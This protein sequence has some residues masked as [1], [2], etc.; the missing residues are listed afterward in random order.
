[1]PQF[2]NH[3]TRQI[4]SGNERESVRVHNHRTMLEKWRMAHF[5]TE[6]VE[7]SGLMPLVR[8]SYKKVL[9]LEWLRNTFSSVT[10]N[11]DEN[12]RTCATRAFLLYVLSCTIFQGK[13]GNMGTL[14]L[15]CLLQNLDN[16]GTY[17]WGTTC[18][19]LLY[20]ALSDALRANTNQISGYLTLL[21]GW[22]YE[23]FPHLTPTVR[24]GEI[25]GPL[26][27]RWV[28]PLK[29]DSSDDRARNLR[30]LIDDLSSDEIIWAPYKVLRDRFPMPEFTWF[31]GIFQ[32]MRTLE[33]Y[34]PDRVLRKFGRV[35]KIPSQP[36]M[37]NAMFR[38][39]KRGTP[40]L[41]FAA[42]PYIYSERWEDHMLNERS[43]S[44]SVVL[45][46]PDTTPDYM[47]WYRERTITKLSTLPVSRP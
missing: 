32:Y 43:I 35:Q 4:L 34:H 22:I 40:H 27:T 29:S 47:D 39:Q 9:K 13:T 14:Q 44:I 42:Y 31:S 45:G 18:L 7:R 26:V 37:S 6:V 11:D 8:H 19:C 16:I 21:Q 41:V 3:I 36:Y 25:E 5:M 10:D 12:K 24:S 30:T 1:M 46:E 28:Y 2:E 17:E 38:K 15:L 23:H 20:E 33:P